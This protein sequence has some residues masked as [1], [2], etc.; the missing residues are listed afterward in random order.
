MT[1]ESDLRLD[2]RNRVRDAISS[3]MPNLLAIPDEAWSLRFHNDYPALSHFDNGMPSLRKQYLAGPR[4]YRQAV[5][6]RGT[7]KT[8]LGV[9]CCSEPV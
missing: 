1:S 6:G 4:D 8:L 2:L 3:T 5:F 7:L 9:R